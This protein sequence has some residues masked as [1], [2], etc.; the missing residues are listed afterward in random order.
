MIHSSLF[1]EEG[2]AKEKKRGNRKTAG[3]FDQPFCK[4]IIYLIQLRVLFRTYHNL[5]EQVRVS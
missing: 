2:Y 5:H 3:Q 1:N 4:T